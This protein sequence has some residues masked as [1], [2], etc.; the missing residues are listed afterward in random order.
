MRA[1]LPACPPAR[2]ARPARR[3]A[4]VVVAD[5][6]IAI[7]ESGARVD[8]SALDDAL[9][10]LVTWAIRACSQPGTEQHP[11]E[12]IL[13]RPAA[14]ADTRTPRHVAACGPED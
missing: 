1:A 5:P 4:A 11:T 9:G 8:P 10:L 6:R 13:E 2:P 7:V 12:A 3:N 14:L